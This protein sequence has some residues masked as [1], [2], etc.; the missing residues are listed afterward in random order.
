MQVY[1]V[2]LKVYP[3]SILVLITI[4]VEYPALNKYNA[5]KRKTIHRAFLTKAGYSSF[6]EIQ[7]LSDFLK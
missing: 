2:P 4:M 3:L 6:N 7:K 1:M 5:M